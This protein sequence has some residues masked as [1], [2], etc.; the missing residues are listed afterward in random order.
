MMGFGTYPYPA[1]SW[2]DDTSMSL[3]DRAASA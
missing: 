2:S 3:A 1:G